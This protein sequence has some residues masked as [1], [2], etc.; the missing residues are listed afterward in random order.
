[1]EKVE[2]GQRKKLR[3]N[4][5]GTWRRRENRRRLN[6]SRREREREYDE[7]EGQKKG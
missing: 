1:M 3:E 7:D 4:R 6:I 5:G 2:L